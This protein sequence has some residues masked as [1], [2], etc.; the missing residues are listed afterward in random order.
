[1]LGPALILEKN[2]FE[3]WFKGKKMPVNSQDEYE[4]WLKKNHPFDS[5]VRQLHQLR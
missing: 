3:W 4:E 2:K 1:V 5:E